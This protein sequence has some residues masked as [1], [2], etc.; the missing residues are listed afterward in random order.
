MSAQI[1]IPTLPEVD[2][3]WA[4]E[5]RASH[6]DRREL[7]RRLELLAVVGAECDSHGATTT[8]LVA[9]RVAFDGRFIDG[10]DEPAAMAKISQRLA[11]LERCGWV[12]RSRGG[13]PSGYGQ[14]LTPAWWTI[15]PAGREVLR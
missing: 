8:S 10:S 14:W 4:R 2:P 5:R 3:D 1:E 13:R 6:D 12:E 15:T 9:G 7:P 11:D